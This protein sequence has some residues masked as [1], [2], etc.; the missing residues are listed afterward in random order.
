[1]TETSDWRKCRWDN[2]HRRILATALEL[3]DDF[4]FD[5]VS[6]S[7]IATRA[8][9]SV[10][11]FYAHYPSKEHVVMALP[12]VEEVG[13]LLATQ[14]AELPIGERVRRAVGR[15]L[16]HMPPDVHDEMALRWR[17]IA[18]TPSLRTRAAEFERETAGMVLQHV[19]PAG[20]TEVVQVGAHLSAYTAGLLAW[21]DSDGR[22]ELAETLDEAFRALS[23]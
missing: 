2:T 11:T 5:Q 1:M 21:A 13:A 23:G 15:M 17:I 7:R 20:T 18:A 8:G 22:R 4:G 19:T 6:V 3:F 16:E 9:V 10:P 14:P 12:T